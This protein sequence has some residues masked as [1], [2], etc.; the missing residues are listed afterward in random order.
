[1]KTIF[2]N[3]I[4]DCVL[5]DLKPSVMALGFFDG[6]HLGHRKL[7]EKAKHISR[8]KGIELAVLTFFPHPKEVLNQ[9]KFNYLLS[10]DRKIEILEQLGVER[11][12][13]VHFNKKFASLAPETFVEKYLISLQVKE[14][15]AGFDFTYGSKGIGNMKTLET[16][17]KGEFRVT[18]IPKVELYGNKISST[19]IRHFLSDGKVEQIAESLGGHYLTK[20]FITQIYSYSDFTSKVKLEVSFFNT[21]PKDGF[22]EVEVL[23]GDH[24]FQS[25][26]NISNGKSKEI[27]VEIEIPSYTNIGNHKELTI[28]WLKQTSKERVE[29]LQEANV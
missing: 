21:P 27:L 12:Y 5:T 15:V 25:T 17:G 10:L 8:Q 22:Y 3:H 9:V 28:K 13:I 11:L 2:L 1:M 14:V 7:L 23:L 19:L 24:K 6:V 26:C 20:G 16:H 18:T 29:M 4:T